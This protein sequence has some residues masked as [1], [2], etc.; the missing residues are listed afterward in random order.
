[1]SSMQIKIAIKVY[2]VSVTKNHKKTNIYTNKNCYGWRKK[3]RHPVTKKLDK[4]AHKKLKR[5]KKHRK[6]FVYIKITNYLK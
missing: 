6:V 5:S 3:L 4:R 1:M 2:M